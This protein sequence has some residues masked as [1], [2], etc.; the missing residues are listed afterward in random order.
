MR[1]W[2]KDLISCLPRQQLLSQWRECC[3][4]VRNIAVNGTPNHV[5]VNKILDYPLSHFV[6]Y[7]LL[8]Y[9]EMVNRQYKVQWSR[10]IQHFPLYCPEYVQ[11]GE[12]F[13]DWHSTRYLRQ[14]YYNLQEKY[15]RGAVPLDEWERIEL[16]WHK[17]IHYEPIIESQ[18]P[19]NHDKHTE[20]QGVDFDNMEEATEI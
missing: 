1:L 19:E 15:D 6:N 2:H 20:S 16:E 17:E 4:I 10:F 11:H 7:T 13:F 12:I 9:N 14:C 5:L 8:V 18:Q 3:C